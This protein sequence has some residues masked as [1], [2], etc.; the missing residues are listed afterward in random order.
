MSVPTDLLGMDIIPQIFGT[1]LPLKKNKMLQV[2]LAA[3]VKV[4]PILLWEIQPSFSKQYPL[5]GGHDEVTACINTL[6]D[7]GV[8]ERTQSFNSPVWL[9]KKPNGT[10][11]FT[12]DF[13]N[14]NE[15]SPAMP[16]NLPDVQDLFYRIQKG[17]YTWFASVDLLDMFFALP[18]H[19]K[20]REM[21]TFTWNNKQYQ[22]KR[23]P[24]RYKNS[25]IIAHVTL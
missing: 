20:S 6:I 16:G 24:Q 17:A 13:R 3:E 22:F 18:L 10:S 15:L 2:D 21:T 14:I 1:W 4:E 19:P 12:V 9:V 23:L 5:K 8:I 25:P 11:R 7:E